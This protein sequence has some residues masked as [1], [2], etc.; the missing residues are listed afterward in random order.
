MRHLPIPFPATSLFTTAQEPA[1]SQNG[2]TPGRR[3]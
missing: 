3:A 2:G 1:A